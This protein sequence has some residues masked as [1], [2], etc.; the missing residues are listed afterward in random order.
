[1]GD[2]ENYHDAKHRHIIR[3]QKAKAGCSFD[4]WVTRESALWQRKSFVQIRRY[5]SIECGD[6]MF[7]DT[8]DDSWQN[9]EILSVTETCY[10]NDCPRGREIL[11]GAVCFDNNPHHDYAVLSFCWIHPFWRNKGKLKSLWPQIKERFSEFYVSTPQTPAMEYFLKSV[12]HI[13]VTP[14]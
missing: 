1:M 14:Q 4:S 2:K 7:M 3:P 6:G 13:D 11:I 10:A 9:V 5:Q 12:G 8:S